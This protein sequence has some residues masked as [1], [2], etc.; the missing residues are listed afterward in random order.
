MGLRLFS[1]LPNGADKEP[2]AP[3]QIAESVTLRVACDLGHAGDE[4]VKP[5]NQPA[6]SLMR[7]PPTSA[8][9][10]MKVFRFMNMGA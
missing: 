8:C 3:Q 10:D 1:R 7:K 5:H 4:A 2:Y 6:A 9:L